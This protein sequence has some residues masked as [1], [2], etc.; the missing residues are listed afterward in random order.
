[1]S[2]N[3]VLIKNIFGQWIYIDTNDFIGVDIMKSG[4][5][6]IVGVYFM[7][8]LLKKIDLPIVLDIGANIG[9]HL[10]PI[11]PF[12]EKAIVFEPQPEI[13]DRLKRSIKENNF[14]NCIIKNYG[15]GCKNEN[16]T[17]Y[18]NAQGNNGASSF[19]EGHHS[20]ENTNILNLPIKNGDTVLD[21]LKIQKLDFI[22]ID[23]ESFEY[24]VLK[25]IQNN[26]KKHSPIILMEWH[27]ETTGQDFL[28]NDIFNNILS[29]YKV[30]ALEPLGYRNIWR[31]VD[32]LWKIRRFFIKNNSVKQFRRYKLTEFD[33]NNNYENVLLFKKAHE[34]IVNEMAGLV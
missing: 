5:F 10:M 34:K 22:K 20:I 21:S 14:T 4:V 18:Q 29:D 9:N 25:G 12:V 17:F 28:K 3:E 32:K 2:S 31:I 8:S 7:R 23:A 27:S 19:V 16:L 15:L 11:L 13:F 30:L 26:I 33:C 24:E 1:M 6:D